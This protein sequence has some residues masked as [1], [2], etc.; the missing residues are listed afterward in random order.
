M[1]GNPVFSMLNFLLNKYISLIY[2]FL[3]RTKKPK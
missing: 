2:L 3:K 1:S